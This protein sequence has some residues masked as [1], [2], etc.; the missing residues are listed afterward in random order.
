MFYA[1]HQSVHLPTIAR[2]SKPGR[3]KA[4]FNSLTGGAPDMMQSQKK[5]TANYR[6]RTPLDMCQMQGLNLPPGFDLSKPPV[7]YMEST[8]YNLGP[9]YPPPKMD[10]C[11]A[12]DWKPESLLALGGGGGTCPSQTQHAHYGQMQQQSAMG[13]YG[14]Y[15]MTSPTG[16]NAAA[17]SPA[18]T[19]H[20]NDQAYVSNMSSSPD[21]PGQW[22]IF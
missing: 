13:M 11:F 17:P 12:G 8:G 5:N 21:S 10:L 15:S 18:M 19:L 2:Y 7:N 22:R 9:Q 20:S 4:Y 6:R 14:K 16:Y 1:T 3:N